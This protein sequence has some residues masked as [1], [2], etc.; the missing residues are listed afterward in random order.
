MFLPNDPMYPKTYNHVLD[1]IQ[2][3]GESLYRNGKIDNK[4]IKVI[5]TKI[6]PKEFQVYANKFWENVVLKNEYFVKSV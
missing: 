3:A 6:E 5:Q 2:I 4:T 1:S